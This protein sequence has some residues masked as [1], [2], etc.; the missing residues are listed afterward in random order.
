MNKSVLAEL[1][2]A[3]GDGRVSTAPEDLAAYAY[4]GTWAETR[5]DVVVHPQETAHVVAALRIADAARVPV[6]PRGS[7]TGLAGG[8][9]PVE[10]SICLN[11]AR[12]NRILEISVPDTV[13]VVQPGVITQD[14][15]RAGREARL[16]L[17]ARPGQRLP[18]HDRR[19]CGDERRRSALPEVWRDRR[20][21]P[22]VGGRAGGRAC[23][24]PGRADDQ[25]RGRV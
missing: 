4:D 23:A 6:V 17:P 7:A 20:L 2:Q 11:L 8:A 5:P 3:L 21:R 25:R 13:A 16:L 22:G 18:V 19:Q 24:A 9:V 12:M 10:G 14:L 15:Q 1:R